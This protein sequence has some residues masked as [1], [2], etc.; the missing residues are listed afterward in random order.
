MR[1]RWLRRLRFGVLGLALLAVWLAMPV[2]ASAVTLSGHASTYG[3]DPV[4]GIVDHGDNNLPALGRRWRYRPGIAVMRGD[5]LGHWWR[6]CSPWG[7]C[8]WVRQTDLGPAPWTGR[9]V[10]VNAVADRILWRLPA[11]QFPT[12]VGTWRLRSY[13]ATLTGVALAEARYQRCGSRRCRATWKRR[14]H[15][16]RRGR[17]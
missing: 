12:D 6:V 3:N 15:A 8:R 7:V 9:A 4:L 10:D 1:R 2:A 17:G 5:T 13:G 14:V 16:E 11:Y